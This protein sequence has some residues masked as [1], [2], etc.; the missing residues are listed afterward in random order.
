LSEPAVH[1]TAIVG[2]G[3]NLGPDTTVGPWCLLDGRV[4][5]G[6]G[7]RLVAGVAVGGPPMDRTYR[8]EETEVRIGDRNT[9]HE[10]STIHR[11][12][13]AGSA[14]VVGDDNVVMTYVHI[15]HNCRVGSGCVLTSGVQLGGHV[16]IGDHASIGGLTGIHQQCRIGTLAMVGACSYVNKDIPPFLLASGS[17]CRVRGVNSV[18]LARARFAPGDVA[19]IR[20]AF[21][22][23]YRSNQNLGQALREVE[24]LPCARLRQLLDFVGSSRRGIELRSAAG[25][26][27]PEAT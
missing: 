21:R 20:Q 17:P 3:A 14:T 5:V 9:F 22:L 10:F 12:T 1:P 11:S 7:N 6:A 23:I 13:G 4:L 26:P 25:G 24:Q 18:G 8:G 16:E 27:E 2:P 15:A 19:V